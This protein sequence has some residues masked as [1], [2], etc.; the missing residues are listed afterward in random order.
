MLCYIPPADTKGSSARSTCG[1]KRQRYIGYPIPALIYSSYISNK[2]AYN[3]NFLQ[4]YQ[5]MV[6]L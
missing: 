2:Y 5:S 4:V 3:L 1:T 6:F